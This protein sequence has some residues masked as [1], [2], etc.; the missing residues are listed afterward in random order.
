MTSLE[1]SVDFNLPR[2]VFFGRTF[3]EYEQ[4]FNFTD[5]ELAG[6]RI[7]D[8]PSGPDSFVAESFNRGLD[9][10][11]CDPVYQ[12][13]SA[14]QLY[15]RAKTDITFCLAQAQ[16]RMD[17]FPTF[18][19]EIFAQ[20]S[21]AK[22]EAMEKFY[23]DFKDRPQAYQVG[24]LPH[25]PF[26]DNSFDWVLSAHFL[27]AYS[28]IES[29]GILP[30]SPFDLDFHHQAM[31]E[32]L[33]IAREQVRLYPIYTNNHPRQRHAYVNPI[34]EKLTQTGHRVEF[35]PSTYNQGS[36]VENFT[37]VIYKNSHS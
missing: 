31:T 8:C 28:S 11:G 20:F 21:Q 17:Q 18:T 32:L 36:P 12:N 25:L 37:L 4:M 22:L 10:V 2:I 14:E 7:L 35:I 27:L 1:P 30:N 6:K 3:A 16:V 26:A 15:E 19:D 33:R 5:A 29:G 23:H 9:V 34:V 24:S 13:Q